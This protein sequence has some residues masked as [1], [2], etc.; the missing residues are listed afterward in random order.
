MIASFV[1]LGPGVTQHFWT[2]RHDKPLVFVRRLSQ[3]HIGHGTCPNVSRLTGWVLAR[4]HGCF[5]A[6]P[7]R[8]IH[9]AGRT[10]TGTAAQVGQD[11]RVAASKRGLAG[12]VQNGLNEASPP[13]RL[14]L[15][16]GLVSISVFAKADAYK[17]PA[18]AKSTSG[19]PGRGFLCVILA[20]P[21][22]NAR[23][24]RNPSL[25][26]LPQT[27]STWSVGALPCP[28]ASARSRPTT[29][30]DASPSCGRP[31]PALR[32]VPPGTLQKARLSTPGNRERP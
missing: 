13:G 10:T 24:G 14:L 29:V 20:D 7:L 18:E 1:T 30:P 12:E 16:R 15:H 4:R 11:D 32:H 31:S 6:V 23:A 19:S 28:D 25:K 26:I 22:T 21:Q 9:R 27:R 2:S 17:L 5:V 3:G 8:C